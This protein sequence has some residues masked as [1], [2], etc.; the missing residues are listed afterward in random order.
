MSDNN[1]DNPVPS[2]DEDELLRT[3]PGEV[4][5]L[6]EGDYLLEEL[7]FEEDETARAVGSIDGSLR[8]AS[9][10]PEEPPFDPFKRKHSKTPVSS[11]KKP[12]NVDPQPVAAPEPEEV[13]DEVVVIE[14]PTPKA[15]VVSPVRITPL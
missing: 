3:P 12:K 6:I 8:A 7:D 15:R 5:R 13:E 10:P 2:A 1:A 9:P 14:Q 11:G 4:D